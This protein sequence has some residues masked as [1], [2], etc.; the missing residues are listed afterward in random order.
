VEYPLLRQAVFSLVISKAKK[1]P[2][3]L[4]PAEWQR[5]SER[6]W[7]KYFCRKMCD[8]KKKMMASCQL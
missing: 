8:K 7:R 3:M 6:V 1:C 2:K 4:L 5:L